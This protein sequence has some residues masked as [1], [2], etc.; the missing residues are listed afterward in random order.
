[1]EF[2]RS[3]HSYL[4]IL[5]IPGLFLI[6]LLDSAAVP[7]LGGPDAVI[8]ILAWQKPHH[9][10]WI[11]L[12]ATAGSLL[13]CFLL[14]HIGRV[15]GD[16]TLSRRRR[17]QPSWAE[18]NIGEHAFG[19]LFVGTLAP[20]PF[21]TKPVVLAAGVFRVGLHKFVAGVLAGRLLRYSLLAYLGSRFGD[22]A[23]QFIRDHY[24]VIL[25]T[26]IGVVVACLILRRL[27]GPRRSGVEAK[28]YAGETD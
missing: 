4:L 5:G 25:G 10:V 6:S 20:P 1:M 27:R 14:Y 12:A 8:L 22:E 2:L 3:L 7:M 16:L 21:P 19:A 18:R 9:L 26:L 28:S 24:L 15:G 23:Q 17:S 11:A 13:G